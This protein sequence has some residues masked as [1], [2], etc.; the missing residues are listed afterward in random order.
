MFNNISEIKRIQ[1]DHTS[2]CNL[3]CPQCARTRDNGRI[4][5][6]DLQMTDLTLNDYKI[7]LAPFENSQLN[8]IFHC[9]NV[10]DVIASPTFNETY[11]Y[12]L[13]YTKKLKIS[14]NGSAR[15][16]SWWKDLAQKGGDKIQVVFAID[17]LEDTN[18]L[19]RINSNF[20]KILSNAKSYI[21]AGGEAHWNF[22]EFGHNYHQIDEARQMAKDYGFK[23]FSVKYTARFAERNVTN[24]AT[25]S[26]YI[27]K[28]IPNSHN[29]IEMSNIEKTHSSFNEYAMTT[30]ISCKW[31]KQERVFIDMNMKLWPCCW[32]G[33]SVYYS[34]DNRENQDIQYLYK[35]YGEGFND[36]RIHGWD[37]LNHSFFQEYLAKSWES[38]DNNF[39][40]IHTCGKLCGTKMEFSSG[41]GRNMNTEIIGVI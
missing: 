36:M 39:K 35:L 33:S 22:I 30:G 38:P 7:I 37:V 3:G 11:E 16:I 15:N 18:H 8:Q 13:N 24:L 29:Q 40:R 34:H 28:D 2:R 17:G 5:N 21:D 19:Y 4:V 23:E 31:K 25:K 1:L 26:G 41:Y 9:G 27:I 12:S 10:G 14:T 32:I 6:S 20:D